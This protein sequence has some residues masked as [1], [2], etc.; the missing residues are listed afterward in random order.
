MTSPLHLNTQA[1]VQQKYIQPYLHNVFV[2]TKHNNLTL[3]PDKTT[4]TLF[5]PD[6]AEY[7]SNQDLKINNTALPMATHPTI[8]GLTLDPN[9]TH[10]TH[11][12]NISVHANKPLQITTA[13]GKQEDTLMATYKAVMKLD[14]EYIS[15]VWS[16]LHP[17]PAL[18]N[19]KS[20]R[21]QHWKVSHDANKTQTYNICMTKHSHYP[22]TST[23]RSTPHNT[24]R[25]HNIHHIPYTNIQ[26]TSTLQR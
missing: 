14:L 23:Y 25:K 22:Y 13:C 1:G 20:C 19:C 6:P 5:T 17:R 15:S 2:W 9:L 12:H 4:C 7:T 16:L 8:L 18:T 3:N 11:I 21:T 26:H 10:S 24:N